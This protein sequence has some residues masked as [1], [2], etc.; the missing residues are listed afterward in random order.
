[1]SRVLVVV[2]ICAIIFVLG[3]V[4]SSPKF[5]LG[6]GLDLRS[7]DPSASKE[8]PQCFTLPLGSGVVSYRLHKVHFSTCSSFPVGV[9]SADPNVGTSDT[10][11]VLTQTSGL[12]TLTD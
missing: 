12:P 4:S 11:E 3:C 7:G 2:V 9:G 6:I 10:S 8:Q 1:M 5:L